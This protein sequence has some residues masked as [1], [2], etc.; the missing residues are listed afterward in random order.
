[1]VVAF[2]TFLNHQSAIAAMHA[3]NGVKFD[4]QAGSVLHIELARSNSRRKR[5]PGSGPYVVIDNRIKA[6]ANTQ[7]T[8]SDDGAPCITDCVMAE[9]E[10]LGQ[11]Y[12]L[13]LRKNQLH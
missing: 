8:S 4:P 9:L 6:S 7:E 13:A 3:L 1:M 5:K 10:K 12:R 2:A 11:K